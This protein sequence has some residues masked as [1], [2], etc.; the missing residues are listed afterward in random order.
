MASGRQQQQQQHSKEENDAAC[1]VIALFGRGMPSLSGNDAERMNTVSAFSDV[2]S[3]KKRI[4]EA[5]KRSLASSQNNQS[6]HQPQEEPTAK[7]VKVTIEKPRESV[8]EDCENEEKKR[9]LQGA[10]FYYYR[11]HSTDPD[12]DPLVPL[13]PPGKT[14]N[15][16]AKMHAILSNPDLADIIEWL[17][18]GRSWR[19]LKPREFEHRVLPR[20]FEHSKYSSFV[21]QTNGWGFRRISVGSDRNSYYNELFLRGLPH[22]CK[23]MK[24]HGVSEKAMI[25]A[26]HEP[27]LGAISKLYPVPQETIQDDLA[28]LE[29]IIDEGPRARMPVRYD[30]IARCTAPALKEDLPKM[31]PES[32]E[33][34]L[35][36]SFSQV[37]QSAEADKF[38]GQYRSEE[39]TS[40][41]SMETEKTKSQSFDSNSSISEGEASQSGSN[42]TNIKKISD[43][44][45]L[46]SYF[47]FL[48]AQENV[49]KQRE[50]QKQKLLQ[51][52]GL[53]TLLGA[54]S[55]RL[56]HV[57]NRPRYNMPVTTTTT[58]TPQSTVVH[59]QLRDMYNRASVASHLEA[60]ASHIR[61]ALSQ[62]ATIQNNPQKQQQQKQQAQQNTQ[63][64]SNFGNTSNSSVDAQ[65][66][67]SL[68]KYNGMK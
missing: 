4:L 18:H 19:I 59:D 31:I 37:T 27:D 34:S 13:T 11:D 48:A 43:A 41:S 8:D 30:A 5:G 65:A 60:A 58:A 49:R 2:S 33:A 55:S 67:A 36:L 68:F 52:Q 38:Q 51:T 15:F 45:T 61:T 32:K 7:K 22:L 14:P 16:P 23:K 64:L 12:D 28:V 26:K 50:L 9:A 3:L 66:L 47:S 6:S 17:P 62:A 20:Y 39:H 57:Q 56:L 54:P 40:C 21:R 25:D 42:F 44:D 63:V 10:P 24:R 1:A 53:L 35:P 29:S 46:T